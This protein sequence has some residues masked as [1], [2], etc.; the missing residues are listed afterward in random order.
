MSLNLLILYFK[1]ILPVTFR[2]PGTVLVKSAYNLN[3][4]TP[5]WRRYAMPALALGFEG[6]KG[7]F[8]H[9]RDPMRMEGRGQVKCGKESVGVREA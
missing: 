9:C 6:V 2:R 1:L 4:S 8:F 5:E 3:A 7:V